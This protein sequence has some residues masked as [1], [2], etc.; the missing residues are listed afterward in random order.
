MTFVLSLNLQLTLLLFVRIR[1][2]KLYFPDLL[3]ATVLD[4]N[5]VLR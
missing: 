2:I 3:T 4:I 1:Q 5:W